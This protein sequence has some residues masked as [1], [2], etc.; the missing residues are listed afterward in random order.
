MYVKYDPVGVVAAL[1]PWNFPIILASRKISTALGAGCAVIC[2]PDVITPGSVM[3]LMNIIRDAGVP[4][5]VVNLLSGDPAGISSQLISSNIQSLS[6]TMEGCPML[7]R[8]L[9]KSSFN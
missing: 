5:G 1:I 7:C 9:P 8:R 4:P 3:E 2:K 6:L